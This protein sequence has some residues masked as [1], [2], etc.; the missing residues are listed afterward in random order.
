MKLIYFAMVSVL[1]A[2]QGCAVYPAYPQSGIVIYPQS[3]SR[4]THPTP[5]MQ[6]PPRPPHRRHH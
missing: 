3:R 1:A 2:I 6:V 4:H 5:P